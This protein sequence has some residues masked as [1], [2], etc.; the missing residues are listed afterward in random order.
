MF[1]IENEF[2]LNA[3]PDDAEAGDAFFNGEFVLLL[4]DP[5]AELTKSPN[6]F[7]FFSTIPMPELE[8]EFAVEPQLFPNIS[9]TIEERALD[10]VGRAA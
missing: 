5:R 10:K 3:A 4:P 9:P 8:P 6:R 7:G 2:L 1:P